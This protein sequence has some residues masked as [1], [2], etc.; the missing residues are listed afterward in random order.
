[1]RD[2]TVNMRFKFLKY[3]YM[4]IY[5]RIL[6][7]LGALPISTMIVVCFWGGRIFDSSY[8]PENKKKKAAQ[9][10]GLDIGR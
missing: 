9:L 5:F 10:L 8:A 7:E 3:H 2:V 6:H 4:F 1:M